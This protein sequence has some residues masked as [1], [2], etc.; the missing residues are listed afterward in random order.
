MHDS[1]S[2]IERHY[3]SQIIEF[4][5]KN[6]F[7]RARTV[8]LVLGGKMKFSEIK[9]VFEDLEVEWDNVKYFFC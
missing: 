3:I 9:K 7:D 2:N 1:F 4:E 5:R 8:K 6:N